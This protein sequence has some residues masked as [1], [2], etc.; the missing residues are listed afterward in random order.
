MMMH[1][2]LLYTND[3]ILGGPDKDEVDQIIKETKEAKLKI[4]MWK[5]DWKIS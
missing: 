5:E 2:L 3:S 1:V 4:T